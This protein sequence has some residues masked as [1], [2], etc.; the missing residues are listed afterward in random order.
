MFVARDV[1]VGGLRLGHSTVEAGEQRGVATSAESVEG[2]T[3]ANK[4]G[5]GSA[6][7]SWTLRQVTR[8]TRG[9]PTTPVSAGAARAPVRHSD[10]DV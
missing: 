1:R 10:S 3:G 9:L 2:R 8:V 6:T 7:R 5:R 4:E